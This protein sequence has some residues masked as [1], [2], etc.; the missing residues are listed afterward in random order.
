MDL[1]GFNQPSCDLF[2]YLSYLFLV[3]CFP[4]FLSF[5][6][7][8]NFTWFHFMA[9]TG[10]KACQLDLADLVFC[11][12]Y[13]FR[14]FLINL[15][16]FKILFHGKMKDTYNTLFSFLPSRPFTTVFIPHYKSTIQCY[17]FLKHTYIINST[18]YCY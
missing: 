17:Y 2:L 18:M 4:F 14:V 7:I 9:I 8:G 12:C 16:F 10:L 3:P 1:F 5:F 11:G 6:W 13:M 15:N